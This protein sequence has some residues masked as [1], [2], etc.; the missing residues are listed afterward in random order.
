MRRKE[1]TEYSATDAGVAE[2]IRDELQ[3]KIAFNPKEQRWYVYDGKVWTPDDCGGAGRLVTTEVIRTIPE[4]DWFWQLRSITDEKKRLRAADTLKLNQLRFTEKY[5]AER[6]IAAALRLARPLM[7]AEFDTSG[8]L[9]FDNGILTPAGTLREHDPGDHITAVIPT[10]YVP[11]AADF[12]RGEEFLHQISCNDPAWVESLFLILGYCLLWGNPEQ[13]FFVFM[14]FG[15][16]GKGVLLTWLDRALGGAVATVNGQELRANNRDQRQTSLAEAISRRRIIISRE[17]G[18]EVLDDEMIKQITGEERVSLKKI[19]TGTEE[20]RVAATLIMVT[21]HL[22]IFANGGKSM[23]RREI[24]V[25]F[26]Y[27]LPVSRQDPDLINKLATPEGNA[28][29]VSRIVSAMLQHRKRAGGGIRESLCP[30][31]LEFSHGAVLEQD[32]T[33]R[34][35]L[36]NLTHE[37]GAKTPGREVYACWY[38]WKYGEVQEFADLRSKDGF[39]GLVSKNPIE[40]NTLYTALKAHGIPITPK[41]RYGTGTARNM[42]I[43]WRLRTD[44]DGVAEAGQTQISP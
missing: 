30:R 33:Q 4:E 27:D 32:E 25:P 23:Q 15:A 12:P 34:F 18:S 28:W 29:L 13:V 16:N 14:G 2:R 8:L 3:G 20:Y 43:G 6:S 19:R 39:A 42:L 11:D 38:E 24:A 31:M 36:E 9:A 7:V 5:E 37:A 10:P 41:G 35:I 40:A 1:G 17:A 26:E 21:N 22:P 44:K